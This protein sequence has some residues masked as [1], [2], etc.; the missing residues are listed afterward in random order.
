MACASMVLLK[1]E[2]DVLPLS[3]NPGEPIALVGPFA[4]MQ[5]DLLGSW[6]MMGRGEEVI[7]VSQAM[8]RRI[9]ADRLVQ[10][11]C[12]WNGVTPD[13]INGIDSLIGQATTVVV[14]LGEFSGLIGEGVST[15]SLT[16]PEE[17][18]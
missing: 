10:G 4:T 2:A 5:N 9:P 16:L 11:G 6:T 18:L 12:S 13:Y 3:A 14:C 15:A 8:A 17:Q 1:N 7:P